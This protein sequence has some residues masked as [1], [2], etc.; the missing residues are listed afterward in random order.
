MGP[1]LELQAVAVEMM[2]RI[3]RPIDLLVVS[4]WDKERLEGPFKSR[5]S[6]EEDSR[7]IDWA[8]EKKGE[9]VDELKIKERTSRLRRTRTA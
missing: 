3:V 2:R 4:D 5:E 8:I 6:M 9:G 1:E 7:M